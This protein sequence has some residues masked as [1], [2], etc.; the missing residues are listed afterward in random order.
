MEIHQ[1]ALSDVVRYID[2]HKHISLEDKESEFKARLKIIRMCKDIDHETRILEIGTG[3]GWF[4]ILCRREGI[5]CKGLEIS[6]Q[7]VDYARWFGHKYGAEPDIELGNIE[8][9]DIGTSRYDIVVASATFEHVEN[10]QRGL[11]RVFNALKPG[12]LLYFYSSNKFSFRSGEYDFP[13]YGWLPNRWRYSLRKARQGEDIMKLGIDFNQFRY[14]QLRRFFK[15][16][17]F[18]KILD[19]VEILDPDNLN[20]PNFHKRAVLK[21]LKAVPPLKHLVLCFSH[22]TLFVCIK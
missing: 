9:V 12:G 6:P 7:L 15:N 4:P 17:G 11:R 2:D 13:L 14:W 19:R 20:N 8:E 10:W 3:T 22:G 16:V 5:S 18:S 1:E 21:I